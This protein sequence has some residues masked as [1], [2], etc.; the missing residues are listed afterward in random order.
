MKREVVVRAGDSVRYC[1]FQKMAESRGF[2]QIH[3][4]MGICT[5]IC[6]FPKED[7]DFFDFDRIK[8]P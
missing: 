6:S 1:D 4:V 3:T 8:S 7:Y 5:N 2:K